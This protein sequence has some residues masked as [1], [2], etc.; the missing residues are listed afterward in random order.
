MRTLSRMLLLSF[1]LQTSWV[2][3][4]E[5]EYPELMV[6]PRA[7]ERLKMEAQEEAESRMLRFW[8]IQLSALST[9][10]SGFASMSL[11]T[12]ASPTTTFAEPSEVV[13]NRRANGL[14]GVGVGGI[15]LLT[16]VVMSM[17]YTPYQKGWNDVKSL[18][19][20]SK[21]EQLTRERLAEEV[22]SDANAMAWRL[23][24][25]S[26][27]TN[28]GANAYAMLAR[29]NTIS[30]TL[31]PVLP[32]LGMALSL[33]P[34]LFKFRWMSVFGQH[35]EYKKKIYGPIASLRPLALDPRSASL[36]PGLTLSIQF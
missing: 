12:Y 18:P 14:I 6:A 24:I 31:Q 20:G 13:N 8:P 5:F 25:M 29:D 22:L 30:G 33:T 2:H 3:A 35:M 36:T 1:A 26:V 4:T 9:M 11:A 27:A 21:R 16:T 34:L 15:W 28:F 32:L 10:V 7:S 17:T 19:S 23:T